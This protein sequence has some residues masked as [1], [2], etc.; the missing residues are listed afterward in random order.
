MPTTPTLETGPKTSGQTSPSNP[1]PSPPL[2][3]FQAPEYLENRQAP[4]RV[5]QPRKLL[6]VYFSNSQSFKLFSELSFYV[7]EIFKDFESLTAMAALT[8]N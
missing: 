6:H 8:E 5:L 4:P 1:E 2:P 7:L 3:V